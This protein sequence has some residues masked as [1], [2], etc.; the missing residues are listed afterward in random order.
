MLS[1]LTRIETAAALE[2]AAGGRRRDKESGAAVDA[3]HQT[4]NELGGPHIA[5]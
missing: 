4:Q 1:V 5:V 2:S 3:R